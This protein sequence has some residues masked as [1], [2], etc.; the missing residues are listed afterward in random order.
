MSWQLDLMDFIIS[1]TTVG[2]LAD[3]EE[4]DDQF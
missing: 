2:H 3:Y 1:N 4:I